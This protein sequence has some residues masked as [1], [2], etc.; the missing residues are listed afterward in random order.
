MSRDFAPCVGREDACRSSVPSDFI[1]AAR[2]RALTPA[3]DLLCR[4]IGLGRRLRAFE[5]S[6]LAQFSTRTI[7]EVGCGTGELLIRIATKFSDADVTGLDADPETL[8]IARGKL[9]AAGQ[10]TR[11]VRGRAESLPFPDASFDLVVSSLMV[12]HLTT[13]QKRAAFAEWRRVL[14]PSGAVVVFDFAAPASGLGRWMTWPLRFNLLEESG[15]NSQ[16]GSPR[17]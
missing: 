15:D 13:D 2:L 16:A 14:A 4:A 8:A 1:P 5:L 6:A 10:R 11:L 3:Y 7:L 12:H 9:D 17:G